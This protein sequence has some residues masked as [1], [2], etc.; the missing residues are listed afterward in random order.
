MAS[1]RI[2]PMVNQVELHPLFT[3]KRLLSFCRTEGIQVQSWRPLMQGRLDFTAYR[4]AVSQVWQNP[5]AN[6]P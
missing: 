1:C 3:Q 5:G 2:K 6:R 4:G